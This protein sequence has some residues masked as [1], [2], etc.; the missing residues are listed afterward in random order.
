ME[1][2]PATARFDAA[3]CLYVLHF[4][5]NDAKLAVLRGIARRLRPD[6]LALVAAGVRRDFGGLQDDVAGARRQYAQRLGMSAEQMAAILARLTTPSDGATEEDYPLLLREAGFQ[7]VT[8]YFH[9]LAAI[10]WIAR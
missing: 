4:L 8:R 10:G 1:D 9:A 2:L 6:G 7:R 5:P 3:T